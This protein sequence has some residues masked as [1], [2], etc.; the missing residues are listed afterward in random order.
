[1][2]RIADTRFGWID[3]PSVG[4]I[5]TVRASTPEAQRALF[6]LA[7][8]STEVTKIGSRLAGTES[9]QVFFK[10]SD[11]TPGAA[12]DTLYA[13]IVERFPDTADAIEPDG[14]MDDFPPS[15]R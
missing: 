12:Y 2:S 1:L 10:S 11:V 13:L 8:A 5:V 3:W 7:G 4:G 15:V 9:F 6:S 14:P